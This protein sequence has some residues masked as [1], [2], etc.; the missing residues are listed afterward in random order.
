LN[1]S[2]KPFV[3]QRI[4]IFRSKANVAKSIRK[5]HVLPA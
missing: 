2:S 5:N 1:A 3:Q 4:Y